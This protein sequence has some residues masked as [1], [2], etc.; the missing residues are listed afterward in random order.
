VAGCGEFQGKRTPVDMLDSHPPTP[1][2]PTGPRQVHR[3][4]FAPSPTGDLHPGS[5][6]A[7]LGSW[8][9]ARQ[10]G[11]AWLIRVEDVDPPREVR[12]ATQRQLEAL[13]AFGL[14]SD[15]PVV[16]QSERGGLYAQALER[17]LAAGHAFECHCSRSDLGASHGI[18]RRCVSGRRRPDPAIRLRVPDGTVITFEDQLQGTIRQDVARDV[19]DFVL[20]RTEGLWAYQLAVVVDDAAQGITDVVRGADLLDSTPRQIFLQRMLELPTPRHAHLPLVVD[21]RG[22][23]LSKSLAAAAVDPGRPLPALHAAWRALRQAPEAVSG[24]VSVEHFL[25]CACAAF[26][27]ARIA[28]VR[29]V[30]FA[31]SQH[32]GFTMAS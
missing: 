13:A 18:H 2:R 1:D 15:E 7:A 14:V 32:T 31:A 22:H 12:G 16:R 24:A 10:A 20:R 28:R 9:L 8:L 25:Q 5:L 3:G 11:G 29:Q 6:A 21:A 30:P 23:K 4:R 27:P 26:D 17:L 19:G